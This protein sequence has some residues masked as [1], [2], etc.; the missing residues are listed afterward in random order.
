M[1][2]RGAKAN[3]NTTASRAIFQEFQSQEFHSQEFHSQEFRSHGFWSGELF[4]ALS[5]YAL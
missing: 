2:S 5:P 1:L 3:P 4:I